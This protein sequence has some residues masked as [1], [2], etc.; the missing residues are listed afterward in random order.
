MDNCRNE[1]HGYFNN[2]FTVTGYL[3]KGG[4]GQSERVFTHRPQDTAHSAP[5]NG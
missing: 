2:A 3:R 1:K 5:H 4:Q